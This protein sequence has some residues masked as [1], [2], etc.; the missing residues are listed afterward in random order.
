MVEVDLITVATVV[1]EEA[2]EVVVADMETRVEATGA[3][4]AAVA[5]ITTTMVVEAATLE[6]VSYLVNHFV[7]FLFL[8]S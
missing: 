5:M 6:E 4:A 2:A 8:F 1:M 7:M 3:V